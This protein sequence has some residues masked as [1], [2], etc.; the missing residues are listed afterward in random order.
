ME[1]QVDQLA[2]VVRSWKLSTSMPNDS[3]VQ[4]TELARVLLGC[5]RT[6]EAGDAEI[7]SG[8]VIAV[9]SDYSIEIIKKVVDPRSGIPSVCSW[10]PTIAE[11]KKALENEMA[12]IRREEDRQ[13]RERMYRAQLEPIVERAQRPTYAELQARCARDGLFIGKPGR[14]G[15]ERPWRPTGITDDDLRAKYPGRSAS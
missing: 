2:N 12:P 10:L 5:Y 14:S 13:E 8:A 1:F 6:G 3:V 9:L 15:H 7:Y 11:I 4:V